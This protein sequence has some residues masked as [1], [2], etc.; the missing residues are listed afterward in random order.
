M[1]V[2]M[3]ELTEAPT[4]T[5]EIA[6]LERRLAILGKQCIAVGKALCKH[7]ETLPLDAI[8]RGPVR[9]RELLGRHRQLLKERWAEEAE[10]YQR[11]R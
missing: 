6:D 10:P 1:E 7:P 8:D 9:L 11:D 4:P 2:P 5:D 3:P